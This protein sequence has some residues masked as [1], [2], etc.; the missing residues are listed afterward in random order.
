LTVLG[1]GQLP[2]CLASGKGGRSS[3][4]ISLDPS[5]GLSSE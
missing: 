4:I 5:L 1:D 3:S 2:E